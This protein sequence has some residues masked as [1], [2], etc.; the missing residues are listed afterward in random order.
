MSRPSRTRPEGTAGLAKAGC[1]ALACTDECRSE[2]RRASSEPV[3][4]AYQSVASALR[5]VPGPPD[6]HP[7]ASAAPARSCGDGEEERRALIDGLRAR[8]GTIERPT[9]GP[10]APPSISRDGAGLAPPPVSAFSPSARP[11]EPLPRG[12]G[13]G[14]PGIDDAWLAGGLATGLH[15]VRPA[16]YGDWAAAVGFA[17]AL[18]VRRD[19]ASAASPLQAAAEGAPILLCWAEA[20]SRDM[21]AP[22]GPGLAAL[23][24]EPA[25]LLL[26]EAARQ[27]DVLWTLEESIRSGSISL[28]IGISGGL[29]LTPSRR[30]SLATEAG[31]TPCLLLTPPESSATASLTRWRIARAPSPSFAADPKAPGAPAWEI[32]LERSRQSRRDTSACI[33]VVEWCDATRRFRLAAPLADRAHGPLRARAGAA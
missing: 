32:A 16:A 33:T 9:L 5:H 7:L 2:A 6:P 27:N 12:W 25:R 11:A 31:R 17:L 3:S 28:A 19:A 23:G 21:G 8:I 30:L 13:L 26:V 18:A 15:E 1:P 10:P 20:W 29:G 24:L 22:H 4:V 14:I